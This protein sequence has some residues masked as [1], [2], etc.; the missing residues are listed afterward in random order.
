MPFA[1]VPDDI[2]RL[3]RHVCYLLIQ[4]LDTSRKA[5]LGAF[6]IRRSFEYI[7]HK[8]FTERVIHVAEDDPACLVRKMFASDPEEFLF[9]CDIRDDRPIRRLNRANRTDWYF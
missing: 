8:D 1:D 9:D 4:S 6:A 7:H 5:R 3:R 2:C